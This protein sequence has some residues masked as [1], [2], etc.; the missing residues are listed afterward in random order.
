MGKRRLFVFF[1]S[2]RLRGKHER[3]LAKQDLRNRRE[4]KPKYR[5]GKY[6]SD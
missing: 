5:T 6:W 4:P 2:D 3:R 1:G